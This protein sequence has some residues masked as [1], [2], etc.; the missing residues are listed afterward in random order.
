MLLVV[1]LCLNNVISVKI[2]C[3]NNPIRIGIL[4]GRQLQ[5][6]PGSGLSWGARRNLLVT[7][8]SSRWTVLMTIRFGMVGKGSISHFD[9]TQ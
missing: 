5:H 4:M 2:I 8:R 3:C 1:H 9:A 7:Y 6:L